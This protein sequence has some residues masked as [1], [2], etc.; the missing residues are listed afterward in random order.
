MQAA[1]QAQ[2]LAESLATTVSIATLQNGN[3]YKRN[4]ILHPV[5]KKKDQLNR[6]FKFNSNNITTE[7]AKTSQRKP[8]DDAVS[9]FVEERFHVKP[10]FGMH[11][12]CKV[13][14]KSERLKGTL[15]FLGHITNLP[16]RNNVIVAGLQL[17]VDEDLGTDGTFL[18]RRYFT[19]PPKRGYFVPFKNCIPV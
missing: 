16:K 11:I 19:A 6:K 13:P 18:G 15:E 7:E 2:K 9:K 10:N 1:A 5:I 12:R 4:K 14:G 3:L 17:D 8:I